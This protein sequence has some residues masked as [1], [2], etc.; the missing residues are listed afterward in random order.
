[1]QNT[2]TNELVPGETLESILGKVPE[3]EQGPTF[4][5]GDVIRI[6]G[7]YYRVTE[8][9]ADRLVFAPHGRSKA[10][11]EEDERRRG[12]RRRRGQRR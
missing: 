9:D 7:Y 8:I 11:H 2:R 3:E 10:G 4:E 6:R 5:V 12:T 1:M